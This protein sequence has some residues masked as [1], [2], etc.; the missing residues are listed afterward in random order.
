VTLRLDHEVLDQKR[1]AGDSV[2]LLAATL[3]LDALEVNTQWERTTV[4]WRKIPMERIE[5]YYPAAKGYIT[6]G[7]YVE[8]V[9]SGDIEVLMQ[10]GSRRARP[11]LA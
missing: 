9:G 2:D 10:P 3:F 4:S 5:F 1:L 11:Y 6:R 8:I 7:A